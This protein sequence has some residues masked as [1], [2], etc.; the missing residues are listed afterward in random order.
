VGIRRWVAEGAVLGGA[1]VRLV[2]TSCGAGGR[3]VWMRERM[4]MLK[5]VQWCVSEGQ[6][7]ATHAQLAAVEAGGEVW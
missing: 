2:F 5:S 1:C 4:K 7:K 3:A 6:S